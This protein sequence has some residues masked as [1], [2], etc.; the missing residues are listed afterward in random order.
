VTGLREHFAETAERAK[1]Y[2]LTGVVHTA[3]RR[4]RMRRAGAAAAAVLVAWVAVA[5]GGFHSASGPMV[6]VDATGEPT[7]GRLGWLPATFGVPDEPVPLPG[8]RGVG[9]GALVYCRD[10]ECLL[11]T[12]D[13]ASYSVPGQIWGLSPDGRWLIYDAGG[14]MMLRLL[15][16]DR[17]EP[18]TAATDVVGWS[19]TGATVVVRQ[20]GV[21]GRVTVVDPDR[22]SVVTVAVPDPGWWQ[23][24]GLA[25]DGDVMLAPRSS[26]TPA[27]PSTTAPPMR[28]T[29]APAAATTTEPVAAPPTNLDFGIVYVDPATGGT[30]GH[31]FPDVDEVYEDWQPWAALKVLAR[32]ATG[33]VVFQPGRRVTTDDTPFYTAGDLI[34]ISPETGTALRRYTLPEPSSV[35]DAAGELVGVVPEGILLRW[36]ST[37]PRIEVVDPSGARHTVSTG[38]AGVELRMVRGGTRF[39]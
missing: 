35:D 37:P 30:R 28:S 12:S 31:P 25:P 8:D 38:P 7:A 2:D 14:A 6:T 17:V 9:E 16:G 19:A 24:K 4:R 33:S 23:P 10:T 11:L 3:R 20:S 26:F 1:Y 39:S 21:D 22:G 34:E 13:G 36:P 15:T 32:P 29:T 5:A 18:V 27:A